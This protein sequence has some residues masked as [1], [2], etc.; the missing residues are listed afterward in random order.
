MTIKDLIPKPQERM[1]VVGATGTGKTTL[2]KCLLTAIGRANPKQ[3]IL[4]IDPKCTYDPED[5]EY[6][7]VRSPSALNWWIRRH[8][9][10]HYRPHPMAQTV[11]DYDEV[12]RWAYNRH[13]I[14]VYTDETYLT[15]HHTTSPDWQR[16]IVTCGRELGVGAIFATQR[17]S[18]IDLR[19]YT[20]SEHKVC[21]YLAHRDDRRRMSQEMG[22]EVMTDPIVA[23]GREHAFWYWN[24]KVRKTG[25]AELN[26]K[27]NGNV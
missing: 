13:D 12:Y 21:F 9:R 18:G 5:R 14:L 11:S 16:A 15:M 3:A 6:K 4:V 26:L 7:M 17:P 8:R 1:L 20:E 24:S 19:V 27:G 25:L 2:S 22:E 23:S 10:I